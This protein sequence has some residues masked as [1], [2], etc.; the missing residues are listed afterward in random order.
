MP[1][2]DTRPRGIA[3]F[4]RREEEQRHGQNY[5]ISETMDVSTNYH[6]MQM[7]FFLN[8]PYEDIALFFSEK[9]MGTN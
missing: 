5:G 2:W 3:S 4:W 1:H 8:Q 9:G 6:G 7:F